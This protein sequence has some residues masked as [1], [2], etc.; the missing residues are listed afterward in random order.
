MSFDL[1]WKDCSECRCRT[2]VA[3]NNDDNSCQ[4]GHLKC[5]H[6]SIP[7]PKAAF[8]L[9]PPEASKV[10]AALA[11][12]AAP[13][14]AP[15]TPARALTTALALSPPAN[16][17]SASGASSVSSRDIT[18]QVSKVFENEVNK[19]L[20]DCFHRALPQC[21]I[22]DFR[23]REIIEDGTK[24]EI[25]SIAYMSHDTLKEGETNNESGIYVVAPQNKSSVK[26]FAAKTTQ[27]KDS[28]YAKKKNLRNDVNKYVIGESYSGDNLKKIKTKVTQLEEK[29]EKMKVRHELQ[30]RSPVSDV[31]CLVGAAILSFMTPLGKSVGRKERADHCKKQIYKVLSCAK[32]P[33][34]YRL[35]QGRRLF[36]CVL[37]ATD[38]AQTAALREVSSGIDSL[39]VGQMATEGKI[40][41]MEEKVDAMYSLL[42]T[43][44]KAVLPGLEEE[45]NGED[46]DPPLHDYGAS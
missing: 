32:T 27:L 44:V 25:D 35:A 10:A 5:F 42:S 14:A 15:P 43:F 45:E 41:A 33:H 36:L 6:E 19:T 1:H 16:S 2:F 29:I 9:H 30:T 23:N 8:H 18:N 4:C 3:S 28:P 7:V 24:V 34:L 46:D 38:A 11:L 31:T 13:P 39:N 21:K 12:S 22:H 17:P 26:V 40:D 20:D 37:S